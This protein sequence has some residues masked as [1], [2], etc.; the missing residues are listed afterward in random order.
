MSGS[1]RKLRKSFITVICVMLIPLVLFGQSSNSETEQL[2]KKIDEL[3]KIIEQLKAERSFSGDI[4]NTLQ[5]H[6]TDFTKH[7]SLQL[8]SLKRKQEASRARIDA[9]TLEIIRLSKQL[10]DPSK[11]YALAKRMKEKQIKKLNVSSNDPKVA[12][13]V[14]DTISAQSIDLAAVKLVREGKSLDQARLLIIDQL[15][16][17]QVLNFYKS[18]KRDDRYKL[19]E[20][21]DGI[22]ENDGSEIT[23]ARRSAIYFFLFAK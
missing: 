1:H 19:Y 12:N 3:S 8:V 17:K 2:H 16:V 15:T 10:E 4:G 6:Q 20:I 23:D 22:V 5:E 13:V 11:R 9:L 21:A 14:V 7:D 18:L